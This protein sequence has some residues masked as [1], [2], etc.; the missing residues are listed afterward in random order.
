MISLGNI[1]DKLMTND[2]TMNVI[3]YL[4]TLS[5]KATGKLLQHLKDIG[6]TNSEAKNSQNFSKG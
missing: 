6:F 2:I 1:F 4:T 3:A 5:S